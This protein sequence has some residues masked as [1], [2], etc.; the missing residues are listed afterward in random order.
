SALQVVGEAADGREA[1]E[2]VEL[3]R[4]DVV[5]MDARMPKL[6]GPAATR[7][8][9]DRWPDV[10]VIILSMYALHEGEALAAGADVF[11]IKGCAPE[12]L[13]GAILGKPRE[14][15]HEPQ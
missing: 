4:P 7:L 11:L 2:H 13:L 9:K 3:A 8:I 5:V 14:A 15:R 12:A 10:R 6:D 1:L